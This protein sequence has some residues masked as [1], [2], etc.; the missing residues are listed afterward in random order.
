VSYE[1]RVT[2][3][4]PE[5]V[6]LEITL[7]GLGSRFVAQILDTVIQTVLVFIV[8]IVIAALGS[9]ENAAG[10]VAGAIG[11]I[12]LFFVIFGYHVLFET[13]ASGRS[14]GKRW[15]GLRVVHAGGR[16]V[17][18]V[19]STIRNL[20]R[21][22]DFLPASYLVGVISVLVSKQNQRLGDHAANT[23]VV[24]ER[25]GGR[26]TRSERRRGRSTDPSPLPD[27]LQLW[28]VTAITQDELATVR[29]FLERRDSLDP[30]ARRRLAWQL[31][32]R[33][34]PKMVGASADLESEAFLEAVAAA[35]AAR[36]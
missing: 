1:D 36:I 32:Q 18:F 23:V 30:A 16:P 24:R 19:T 28:D 3:A 29:R 33:L 11:I 25:S 17:G 7:A 21:I 12:L 9:T 22:V 15:T 35:K 34:R 20:L 5:G 31:E 26:H 6:D 14:P 13:L 10:I 27:D 8:S 2:F 4:T